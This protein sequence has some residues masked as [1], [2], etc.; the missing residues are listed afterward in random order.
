M[1]KILILFYYYTLL[2]PFKL[3]FIL[4]ISN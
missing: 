3:F 2:L 1:S 4:F